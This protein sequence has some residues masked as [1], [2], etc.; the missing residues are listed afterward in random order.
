M[1]QNL[2]AS[3]QGTGREM[4]GA[5]GTAALLEKRVASNTEAPSSDV[6][7]HVASKRGVV[8]CPTDR[9][10]CGPRMDLTDA[11]VIFEQDKCIGE[12]VDDG[13]RHT[14]HPKTLACEAE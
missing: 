10:R 5:D 12:T 8:Q 14:S 2:D 1:E 9:G 13:E 7:S 4:I 6:A 3:E 11:E